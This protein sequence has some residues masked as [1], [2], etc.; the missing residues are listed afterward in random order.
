MQADAI[1]VAG[2]TALA[3][4]PGVIAYIQTAYRHF[5]TIAAWGSGVQVL[6]AAGIGVDEPGVVIV[7]RFSKRFAG[8]VIS[9]MSTHR[10]WERAGVHPTRSPQ[11]AL[12]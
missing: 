9:A 10:H 6:E 2:G 12:V 7:D 8:S 5:K 4:Q 3:D 1:V 11:E